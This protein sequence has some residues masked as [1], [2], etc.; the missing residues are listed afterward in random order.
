MLYFKLLLN[1]KYNFLLL[2]QLIEQIK[3]LDLSTKEDHV[4]FLTGATSRTWS[5]I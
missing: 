2:D 1:L 5:S 4:W 3:F